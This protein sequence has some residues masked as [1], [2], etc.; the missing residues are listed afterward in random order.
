MVL[1]IFYEIIY[2]K[3]FI[4]FYRHVEDAVIHLLVT[5]K[6]LLETQEIRVFSVNKDQKENREN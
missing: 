3:Y 2:R 6:E 4:G 5:A 1:V